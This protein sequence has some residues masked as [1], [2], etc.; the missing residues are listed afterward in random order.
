MSLFSANRGGDPEALWRGARSERFGP[1]RAAVPGAPAG[2]IAQG[3]PGH[4]PA[5]YRGG[6]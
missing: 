6:D 3:A 5:D 2:G 1:V 4:L